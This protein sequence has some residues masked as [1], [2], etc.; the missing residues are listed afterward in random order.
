MA[1]PVPFDPSFYIRQLVSGFSIEN[2]AA[3]H[4]VFWSAAARRRFAGMGLAPSG[5]VDGKGQYLAASGVGSILR[6]S[7]RFEEFVELRVPFVRAQPIRDL[8]LSRIE[9]D[10]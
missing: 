8:L 5:R 2:P 1:F 6:G 7:A 9:R 4:G 3:S 10:C